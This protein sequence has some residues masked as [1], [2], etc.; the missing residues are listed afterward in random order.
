MPRGSQIALMASR[1][2][3]TP[4]CSTEITA[5]VVGVRAAATV[6]AVSVP[7]TGSTSAKIGWAPTYTTT[8]A[9]AMKEKDGTTTSSPALTPATT[10]ARCSAVVQ[11]ET[12]TAYAAC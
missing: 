5:V 8:F 7:V 9:V 4:P 6:S 1:S 2:T 11:L 12:A 10:S 3:G